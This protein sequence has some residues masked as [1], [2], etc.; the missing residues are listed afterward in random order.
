[1]KYITPSAMRELE[2]RASGYG[3]TVSMLMEN[4][5]RG[6]AEIVVSRYGTGRRVTAV[7]GSGNNGG[8]GLVAARYLSTSCDTSVILLSDPAKIR[9]AE[10]RENW[11]RLAGSGVRNVVIA[12][13]EQALARKEIASL[14]AEADV[15]VVAL[16]GTG[17]RGH[18]REPLATAI[19]MVNS[20]RAAKVAVDV[21]SGLDPE[22]G[23]V[24]EL[25]V[26]A[27]I[28][29]TMHLPKVGLKGREEYTGEIVVVPIGIRT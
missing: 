23:E 24:G 29:A 9:T 16:V 28:T 26:R 18:V 14:V 10:S 17:L 13:D 27:D 20:S 11:A 22:T 12:P 15:I 2:E 5:G 4:A 3:V 19:R 1:M 21:P 25:T 7:C 8:D 6:V